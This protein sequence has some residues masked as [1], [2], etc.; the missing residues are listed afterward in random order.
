MSARPDSRLDGGA[1]MWTTGNPQV[2]AFLGIPESR[3]Q[4]RLVKR[5]LV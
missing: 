5:G 1:V 2:A 4:R 3:Q